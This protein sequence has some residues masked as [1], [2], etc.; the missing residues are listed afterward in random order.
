MGRCQYRLSGSLNIL[1]EIAASALKVFVEKTSLAVPASKLIAVNAD[2]IC[3]K[4]KLTSKARKL[5]MVKV[6]RSLPS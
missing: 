2:C 6:L 4:V 1:Q 5:V 3:D